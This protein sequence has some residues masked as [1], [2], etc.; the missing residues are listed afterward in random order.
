MLQIVPGEKMTK[1]DFL[2]IG[3][4]F[5][6][7]FLQGTVIFLCWNHVFSFSPLSWSQAVAFRFMISQFSM[8]KN[9]Y[10]LKEE[11]QNEIEIEQEIE[12][13]VSEKAQILTDYL[14]KKSK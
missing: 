8:P 5:T 6:M 10:R 13:E 12:S 14:L 7:Y 9:K 2:Y 11:R 1:Q 4:R 3:V